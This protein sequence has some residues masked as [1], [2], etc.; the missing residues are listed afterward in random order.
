MQ[1]KL[2]F[3]KLQ[4]E[5]FLLEHELRKEVLQIELQLKKQQLLNAQ[6]NGCLK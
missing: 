6:L 3:M 4:I 1:A 5:T 2:D